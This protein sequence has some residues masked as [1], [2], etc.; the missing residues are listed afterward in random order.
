MSRFLGSHP[1]TDR[2]FA[3]QI[4]R[5]GSR[6]S[7]C[8]FYGAFLPGRRR[9][10]EPGLRPDLGLK[11]WPA[12]ELGASIKGDGTTRDVGQVADSFHDLSHDGF[13]ALI[14]VL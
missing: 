14:W 8:V 4:C 13:G 7:V 3:L 2:R 6:T 5:E 9:I 11:V 1:L 12:D 10:A